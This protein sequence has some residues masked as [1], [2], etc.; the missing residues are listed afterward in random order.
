[1]LTA[2]FFT[3]IFTT[4]LWL[5]YSI[6]YVDEQ[7]KN[8]AVETLGMIDFATIVMVVTFPLFVI[9][10]VFGYVNQFLSNKRNNDNL[11]SLFKQMR[12]NQEYTDL[13]ARIMLEAEQN[14]K[15]GFIIN[16]FDL[17]IND[18]NELLSEII[19]RCSLASAEQ[20][21]TLWSKTK[22]GGK[23]AFGKVIVE[24]N[25]NQPSFQLRIFDKS[26]NDP[27]L[28]G[29]IMEFS[30]RYLSLIGLLEK[31]DK[32]RVFLT[33]IE[34]GI[35]GKVFS[36]MAPVSDEIKRNREVRTEDRRPST[37]FPPAME[38]GEVKE[39]IV[40]KLNIFKKKEENKEP[41]EKKDPF[42]M[43]LERSFSDKPVEP[44]FDARPFEETDTDRALSNIKKEWEDFEKPSMAEE[45][46]KKEPDEEVLSYPFSGWADEE[47]YVK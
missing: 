26:Q 39:S 20:I 37:I 16:K 5:I 33:I 7:L 13:V 9:W 15:D 3:A 32:E 8:V 28:A 14:I 12:K 11:F 42:S 17:F 47:N 10:S 45:N 29:T 44:K 35:F 21:E 34:T 41:E 2:A 36:I 22:N 6:M 1:M 27:V 24:V 25:A 18:M 40:S 19:Y 4:V 43:A 38:L 23:W 30:A 46:P 31:H